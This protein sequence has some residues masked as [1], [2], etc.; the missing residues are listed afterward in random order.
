MWADRG[1][2]VSLVENP[3]A[4]SG[5][6]RPQGYGII[7]LRCVECSSFFA[8]FSVRVRFRKIRDVLHAR[9]SVW[10]FLCAPALSEDRAADSDRC[11]VARRWS[12][13]LLSR[14]DSVTQEI[15]DWCEPVIDNIVQED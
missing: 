12:F 15:G 9:A 3:K 8:L 14:F 11:G 7:D 6:D 4:S 2:A 13:F 10:G 1:A 5:G